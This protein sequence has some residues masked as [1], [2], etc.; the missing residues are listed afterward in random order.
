MILYFKEE[1]TIGGTI[2]EKMKAKKLLITLLLILILPNY[3]IYATN[4]NESKNTNEDELNLYS[5][6]AVLIDSNTGTVL[7]SKNGEERK[8]PAST[9]KILSAIIA[10]ETCDLDEIVTVQQSAVS[11]I[12]AGYSSAY[13]TDG[14][15]ISVRDLLTVFLVHSANEAGYV[16]AEHIS[17]SIENF[18]DLMNQKAKEIGCTN[19]HFVNPSGIH[20]DNHYSSAYDLSL[21]AKY[22]MK[23][24]TFRNL[25]SLQSCTIEATNKSDSRYYANTNDLINPSSKYYLEDCIGIKTGFT[26]EAKNCLISCCSRNNLELICVV[27]GASATDNG[28]SARYIDSRALFDYGYSN[29]SIKNVAQKNEIVSTTQIANAT[30]ETRNLDLLLSDDLNILVENNTEIPE[31][32]IYLNEN[33]NAPITENSVVGTI[34]YSIDGVNYSQDLLASHSVEKNDFLVIVFK[35]ALA[36]IILLILMTILFSKSKKK[37]KRRYKYARHY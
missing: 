26:S 24:S 13:L 23:N 10:I 34:N 28:D 5:E 6:A 1:K 7:Y 11:Q 17:G 20:D 21:I 27:L 36:I 4:E 15:E 9:T 31:P 8:Y 29:Y 14:E 12:P 35:T 25:V 32:T 37:K 2:K 22:C 18:A 33:L 3:N 16:L 30:K 19:S